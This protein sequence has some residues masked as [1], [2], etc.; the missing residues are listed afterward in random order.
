MCDLV[1][2]GAGSLGMLVA[3]H[4]RQTHPG[5]QVT[6]KFRSEEG[7]RR[8]R[9]EAEGFSVISKAGGEA[10]SAPL[11][12]FCAPP[13]GNP[14]YEADIRT[15]TEQHWAGSQPGAALWILHGDKVT[16]MCA[17]RCQVTR[18]RWCDACDRK[19]KPES[20]RSVRGPY[21]GQPGAP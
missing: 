18:L 17:Y 14:Q 7:E 12:V 20:W 2:V 5:A 19:P 13:T 1:V 15:T 21:D 11:V 8:R 10:C 9:L 6:L 16:V 4:W 3:R